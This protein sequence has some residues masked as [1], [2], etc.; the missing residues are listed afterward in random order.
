M[1]RLKRTKDKRNRRNE[2]NICFK[3]KTHNVAINN[4]Q[5]KRRKII[6]KQEL[7]SISTLTM[8]C[9]SVKQKWK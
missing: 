4:S 7:Y 8:P 9:N 3:G 6:R 2:Q 5:L 1:W